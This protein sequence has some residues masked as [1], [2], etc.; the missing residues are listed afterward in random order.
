VRRTRPE[1][2]S[3][4]A[5]ALARSLRHTLTMTANRPPAKDT[6]TQVRSLVEEE[7]ERVKTLEDAESVIRRAEQLAASKTEAQAGKGAAEAPGSAVTDV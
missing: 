5:T 1:D 7:L 4:V 6:R 2:D 3:P